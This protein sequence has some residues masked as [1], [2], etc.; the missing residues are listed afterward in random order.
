M[1]RAA[2]GG[3]RGTRAESLEGR[4]RSLLDLCSIPVILSGS[5]A[6]VVI[7]SQRG[8]VCMLTSQPPTH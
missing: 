3:P 4:M 1:S 8:S 7:P 5:Y 2:G 6:P